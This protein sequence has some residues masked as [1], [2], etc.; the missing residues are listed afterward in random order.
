MVVVSVM[1]LMYSLKLSDSADEGLHA[2]TDMA[3][4][5]RCL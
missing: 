5:M 2:N 1:E 3:S 4:L